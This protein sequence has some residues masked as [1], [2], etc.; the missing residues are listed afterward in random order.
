M[1]P[2]AFAGRRVGGRWRRAW[3]AAPAGPRRDSVLLEDMR[4]WTPVALDLEAAEP[5]VEWCDLRGVA[6][7][8][9][10][11]AQTVQRWTTG[12]APRPL[13]RTGLAALE[14]A[15]DGAPDPA[16]FIFHMAR[17]GSTL[18]ARMLG[19]IAG[20]RMISEAEPINSL[21]AHR[22]PA[23]AHEERVRLLR[24]V[25]RA[26]GA[27]GGGAEQRTVVKFSS[28]AVHHLALVR[29]AFPA[30]PW[31]WL[32]R[33]PG[34]VLASL[35]ARPAGWMQLRFKPRLAEELLGITSRA[36]IARP[37]SFAAAA[38]AAFAADALAAAAGDDDRALF[39]PY[40][41][42]PAAVWETMAPAFSLAPDQRD[43]AAMAEESTL[44][45][46]EATPTRFVPK[47]YA[48]QPVPPSLDDL[49]RQMEARSRPGRTLP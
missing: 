28:W 33:E 49:H 46:H 48:L 43:L 35:L 16:G 11:F 30:V 22:W 26:L 38:L 2:V 45:A 19:R 4:A 18:A 5:A 20:V 12:E 24:S 7:G 44:A 10:F 36:S 27:G 9:P 32:H 1:H 47:T 8:E 41:D 23:L 37:D 25:V 13:I 21:L 6:F 34:P 31:V 39:I 42:L 40:R 17:C 14:S 15:A 29:E 3:V